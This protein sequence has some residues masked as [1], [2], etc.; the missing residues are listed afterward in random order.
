LST[1]TKGKQG[2]PKNSR[3][4]ERGKE[5]GD[6]SKRAR[7]ETGHLKCRVEQVVAPKHCTGESRGQGEREAGLANPGKE[8]Q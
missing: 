7:R 4:P 1:G 8:K 5:P 2:A 6:E 3:V